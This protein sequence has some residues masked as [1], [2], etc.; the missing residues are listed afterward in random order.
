MSRRI[1]TA[2]LFLAISFAWLPQNAQ[3]WSRKGHLIITRSAVKLLLDDPK[4]PQALKVLLQEGLGR[5]NKTANLEEFV[6][7]ADNLERLDPGLDLYSYRPDELVGARSSVPSFG[8]LEE[9]MHYLDTEV[10]NSDPARRKFSPDGNN[11]VRLSD[12]PRNRND[13]RYHEYGLVTFRTE[14]CYQD[15]VQSLKTNYS[16]EQVFLWLGF[17]SHY[18][19]DS[20]QPYHSTVDYRG[21]ECPCNQ[22]REKKHDFHPNLE[23]TLFRDGSE[24]GRQLRARFWQYFQEALSVRLEES[25]RNSSSSR[26]RLDPYLVTQK[27]LLSGYDYLPMLCRAGAVALA[28]EQFD[29]YAWFNYRESV[30]HREISVLQL[31]AERMALATVAVRDLILQAWN[32]AQKKKGR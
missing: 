28:R 27:A 4:T 20:F 8:N 18:L 13:A 3:A 26:S 15:L 19:S 14:Q 11:K 21:F 24:S 23:G 5:E 6:I 2:L 17:L 10:F 30:E 29:A 7:E 25:K 32:E 22:S 12:L 1:I 31:K 16:N 9:K